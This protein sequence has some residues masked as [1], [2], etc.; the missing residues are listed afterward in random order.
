MNKNFPLIFSVSIV[1][2]L[3]VGFWWVGTQKSNVAATNFE[4]CAAKGN[5]IMES[6][7][8]QCRDGEETFIEDI[9]NE[10]EKA[11]LIRL[12]NP[13]PNQTILSPLII[14]G[15]ARGNWFFEASFPVVLID[16]DGLIIVQGIA[17]AKDEWMTT[18]FV[19]FEATLTFAVNKN[20][21]NKKGLLILKKDNPSGLPEHDDAL[22]I[23]VVF[24]AITGS[25]PEPVF[26]TMDAKLCPD[27]SYV[28]REGP[29]CEFRKCPDVSQTNSGVK[30][31]VMLGPVCPV[32]QDPPDPQCADRP[33]ETTIQVIKVGSPQSAPF[34]TTQTDSN[35]RYSVT[36]PPG[37][38]A[39]QPL[40]GN[41]FPS[42]ETKEVTVV[43]SK[44]IE[45]NL[46]CDTGIR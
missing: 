45:A 1:V 20:I 15:E 31:Q 19:P 26:C 32:M 5:A 30:G 21:S 18:N 41:V 3:V 9:G 23:P 33:Y 40:G 10:L 38:Y 25:E 13:R 14:T 34:K 7:P 11:D 8:R 4:E 17:T 2:I 28:G 27:G 39:L 36:L 42:C 24:G 6:Y 29:K 22:E 35:G 37:D 12:N 43:A 16:Q 46:S 44:I